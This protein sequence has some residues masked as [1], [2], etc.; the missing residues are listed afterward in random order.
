MHSVHHS[1]DLSEN[2]KPTC[3]KCSSILIH[4]TKVS[5]SDD[6]IVNNNDNL[7]EIVT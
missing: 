3:N 6:D 7:M 1:L 4:P 5:F 2:S